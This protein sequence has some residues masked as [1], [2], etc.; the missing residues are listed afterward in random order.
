MN[1]LQLSEVHSVSSPEEMLAYYR[2]RIDSLELER[3]S[4][5]RAMIN[6]ENG[7]GV[8]HI[9]GGLNGRGNWSDYLDQIKAIINHFRGWII[10]L[11]NDVLDDIWYLQIGFKL[12]DEIW[13]TNFMKSL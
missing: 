13:K 8:L 3:V 6:N 12:H 11:E 2:G 7:V 4:V 1:K 5:E 9:C 10:K